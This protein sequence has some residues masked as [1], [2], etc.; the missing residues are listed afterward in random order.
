MG[1]GTHGAV[2]KVNLVKRFMAGFTG[3]SPVVAK[4]L[5]TGLR[6]PEF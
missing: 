5:D 1:A 6:L 2:N 3:T 4:L